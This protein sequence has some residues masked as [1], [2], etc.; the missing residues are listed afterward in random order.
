MTDMARYPVLLEDRGAGRVLIDPLPPPSKIVCLGRSYRDHAAEQGANVTEKPLLFAKFPS[1]LIRTGE[2]ILKPA[3]TEKLDYEA[4]LA[5]VIGKRCRNVPPERALDSVFGYMNLNDVSARDLQAAEKQWTRSKSFDTFAPCGPFV[6]TADE[7]PNPDDLSVRC[8][9]NGELRQD[10]RTS[11]LMY[12]TREIL[13]YISR[14]MTLYPGDIV[15]TGTPAGVGAFRTPPVF[16]KAGDRV[17][18]EVEGLGRLSNRVE[19]KD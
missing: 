7:V 13:S 11:Q 10:A 3:E 14:T 12:T 16:L 5:I 6:V 2:P 8:W 4:E 9:V 17:E 19:T 1:A 15:S 18:V